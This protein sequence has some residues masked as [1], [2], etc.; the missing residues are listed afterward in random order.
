MNNAWQTYA[1][2]H[3]PSGVYSRSTSQGAGYDS[4]PYPEGDYYL[5]IQAAL[6][7]WFAYMPIR[8]GVTVVT[9][10]GNV[11]SVSADLATVNANAAST[12]PGPYFSSGAATPAYYVNGN[13]AVPGAA[14]TNVTS[15]MRWQMSMQQRA[16]TFPGLLT[17]ALTED[18]VAYRNSAN[19]VDQNGYYSLITATQAPAVVAAMAKLTGSPSTW[20]PAGIAAVT[21]AYQT[22]QSLQGAF[23]NCSTDVVDGPVCF[24]SFNSPNQHIIGTSAV[25]FIASTFGAATTPFQVWASQTCNFPSAGSDLYSAVYP[26]GVNSRANVSGYTPRNNYLTDSLNGG[27]FGYLAGTASPAALAGLPWNVDGWDGYQF[28]RQQLLTAM[29]QFGDNVIINSGA[30]QYLARFTCLLFRLCLPPPPLP[31]YALQP[32]FGD[33]APSAHC[34]GPPAQPLQGDRS[35]AARS[36]YLFNS[37]MCAQVTPTPSGPPRRAPTARW[38]RRTWWSGAAAR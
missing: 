10:T 29:T 28:E 2:N 30:C 36:S 14:A 16:F 37:H 24:E 21:K 20:S 23:Y 8:D 4:T 13:Q 17:Y 7:S 25:N 15:L 9:G 32:C 22:A 31:L 35:T 3:Q 34:P 12:F 26:T 11:G 5:R 6:T 33:E 27:T 19:A 1:E 18:R 38:A